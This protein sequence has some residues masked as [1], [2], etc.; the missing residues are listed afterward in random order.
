MRNDTSKTIGF[1]SDPERINVAMSR[2]KD[3][4]VVVSSSAMWQMHPKSPMHSV[5]E[6]VR[7]LAAIDDAVFVPS[8]DLKRSVAHA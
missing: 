7:R 1:L 8:Q 3:R 6:E 4:L 2:A 5:F